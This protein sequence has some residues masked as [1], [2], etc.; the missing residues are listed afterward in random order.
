MSKR[1]QKLADCQ[2]IDIHYH[3]EPDLYQRRLTAIEA[4]KIYQSLQGIVV[5]KSHLGA[6]SVQATLAQKQGLP[7]LPSL[8]LN[9]IAGGIDYRVI[10][11][12]LAEYQPLIPAKMIVHFPTIT[13]RKFQSKLSRQ[14][15]HPALSEQ[16]FVG[17]TV[18]DERKRLRRKAIDVLKMT[19]DYPLV[20]ST[21][22]ASKDETYALLDACV[23][24]RVPALLLNQPAH[25]LTALLAEE[26]QEISQHDFVWIEQTVLTYLLGHQDSDDLAKVLRQV[27]RVIYSSDLGQTSQMDITDWLNYSANLFAELG[28]SS[29][30]KE[31]LCRT[32]ALALLSL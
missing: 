17:E 7:V 19:Q 15:V 20:L 2:F 3:A 6:T 10:L 5:L 13:G 21:G 16:C 31:A 23:R 27:P 26:L 30:R 4:G 18:F 22:H 1:L 28:L 25:P 9:H 24:Y 12:A 14:L 29:E 11:R 32:N 8:V